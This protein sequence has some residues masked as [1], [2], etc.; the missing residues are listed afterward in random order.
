[1]NDEAKSI[2][3]ILYELAQKYQ[4]ETGKA[5]VLRYLLRFDVR[6]AKLH[7]LAGFD[8]LLA[9][10][11]ISRETHAK[12]VRELEIHPGYLMKIRAQ[13]VTFTTQN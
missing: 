5:E 2:G 13:M 10:K 3:E 6:S 1:M 11:T 9:K 4:N 12:C 8:S 7:L